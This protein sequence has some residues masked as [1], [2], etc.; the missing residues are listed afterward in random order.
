MHVNLAKR[1][2]SRARWYL[3]CLLLAV[4][5]LFVSGPSPSA[6]QT[7]SS[8]EDELLDAVARGDSAMSAGQFVNAVA[9]YDIAIGLADPTKK[10][11]QAGLFYKKALAFRGAGKILLALDSVEWALFNQERELFRSLQA[12]LQ[13]AASRTIVDSE[14][15]RDVLAGRSFIVAGGAA[16]LNLWVRFEFDS[17]R[18]TREG[19]LQ[20]RQM[21]D[22][23]L[24]PEFDGRRFLLVGHTDVTGPADYNLDLSK[25]RASRLREWLVDRY[26]FNA[27]TVRTDGRGEEEPVSRGNTTDDHARNRRVELRLLD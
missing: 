21:A 12:D 20:V 23:M 9:A 7:D 15:I 8:A 27:D 14:Q 3:A 16:S 13:S 5:H 10:T 4:F 11:V 18:L 1:R 2:G 26:D 19:A 6:G 24:S 22:A 17:A 25:R